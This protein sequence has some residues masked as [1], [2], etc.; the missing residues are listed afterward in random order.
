MSC[1][2]P[3][4]FARFMAKSPLL[5]WYTGVS[6]VFMYFGFSSVSI[7]P[8]KATTFPLRSKIGNIT[9]PLYLSNR[10][11]FFE[12]LTMSDCISSSLVYPSFRRWFVS[13]NPLSGAYPSPKCFM[14]PGSSPRPLR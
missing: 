2:L 7:R 3:E 11:P 6:E 9:L 5:L 8:P 1:L 10:L 14:V 13:P 12:V 4:F